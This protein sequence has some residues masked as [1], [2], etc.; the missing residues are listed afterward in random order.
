LVEKYR[1]YGSHCL[2]CDT[3]HSDRDFSRY[4]FISGKEVEKG[5]IEVSRFFEKPGK[6]VARKENLSYFQ[7]SSMLFT[8]DIFKYIANTLS[9]LKINQ[10]FYVAD[11]ITEMLKER[12][13]VIGVKITD[14]VYM[15]T[16]NKLDYLKAVVE[17]GCANGKIGPDFKKWL[18]TYSSQI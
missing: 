13:K 16:G 18:K 3:A 7:G 1:K 8:P 6:D 15:D 5:V 17:F 14:S 2:S 12:Q 4:G 10:E 9:K 11:I